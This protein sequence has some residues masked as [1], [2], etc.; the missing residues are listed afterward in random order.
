MTCS[1]IGWITDYIHGFKTC[2]VYT[3]FQFKYVAFHLCIVLPS[4]VYIV[5]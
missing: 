2:G 5:A 4:G 3:R 1:T